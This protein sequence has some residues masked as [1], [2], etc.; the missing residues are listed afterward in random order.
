MITKDE[1]VVMDTLSQ[2]RR[3]CRKEKLLLHLHNVTGRVAASFSN[4]EMFGY[5]SLLQFSGAQPETF[6]GR[7]RFVELG[8]F[9]K[10]FVKNTRKEGPAEKKFEAFSPRYS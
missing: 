1:F 3:H 9:D 8:D 10:L 5:I 6:Q 7:G 2:V 4:M